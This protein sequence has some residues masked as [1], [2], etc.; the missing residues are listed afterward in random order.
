M[1]GILSGNID[2]QQGEKK[3]EEEGNVEKAMHYWLVE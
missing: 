2:H 3:G 1:I